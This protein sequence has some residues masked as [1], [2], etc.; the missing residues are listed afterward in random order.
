MLVASKFRYFTRKVNNT[1]FMELLSGFSAL[2]CM[3]W[4]PYTPKTI[5]G[6]YGL[7]SLHIYCAH[8]PHLVCFQ[9]LAESFFRSQNRSGTRIEVV[10][11]LVSK[12]HCGMPN[13][14]INYWCFCLFLCFELLKAT[15]WVVVWH[16]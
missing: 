3:T 11:F 6:H 7:K 5:Q 4:T 2:M 9:N 8:L 14:G 10:L 1:Y 15:E 16:F 12:I 13:G